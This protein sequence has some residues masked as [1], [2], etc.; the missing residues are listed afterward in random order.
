VVS[1]TGASGSDTRDA[2]FSPVLSIVSEHESEEDTQKSVDDGEL[3]LDQMAKHRRIK[4]DLVLM[5]WRMLL[6][7]FLETR[8]KIWTVVKRITLWEM[9]IAQLRNLFNFV[10]I[11]MNVLST[12]G[13]DMSKRLV[14]WLM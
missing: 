9:L 7:I 11:Y 2:S 12:P 14:L 5:R 6:R 13:V 8:E 3:L 1:S 10:V 4:L